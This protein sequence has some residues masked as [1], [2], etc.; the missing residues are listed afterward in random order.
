MIRLLESPSIRRKYSC[1]S[2]KLREFPAGLTSQ[3]NL[4][5][6]QNAFVAKLSP[7]PPTLLYSTYFSG[8]GAAGIAVDNAGD[9]TI[10]GRFLSPSPGALVFFLWYPTYHPLVVN[11]Y[12]AQIDP[13]PGRHSCIRLS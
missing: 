1:N 2:D 5:N 9:A 12:A 10:V 11:G 3:A 8:D 13:N 6:F 4:D 7:N